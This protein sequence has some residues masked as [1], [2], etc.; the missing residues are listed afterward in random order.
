MTIESLTPS[1]QLIV[2]V[3]LGPTSLQLCLNLEMSNNS[4]N[5][6]FSGERLICNPYLIIIV[7]RFA[8]ADND[9]IRAANESSALK[10]NI[11]VKLKFNCNEFDEKP[12]FEGIRNWLNFRLRS[13]LCKG[14]L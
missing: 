4:N 10:M 2:E 1:H 9:K 7:P 13:F 12:I 14:T 8:R 3:G 5:V 11:I 6:H